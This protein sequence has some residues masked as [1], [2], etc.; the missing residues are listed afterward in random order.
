LQILDERGDGLDHVSVYHLVAAN[1]V[2][3]ASDSFGDQ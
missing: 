1:L 3:I 2:D